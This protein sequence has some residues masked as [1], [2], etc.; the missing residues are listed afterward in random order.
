MANEFNLPNDPLL[1]GKIIDS[2]NEIIKKKV[3]HGFLGLFWGSSSSIPNNI[4]A[5]TIV[6]LV[7]FGVIYSVS[8]SNTKTEEIGLTIKDCWAI[9]SPIIMLAFGYLF[10]ENT[11][12]NTP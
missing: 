3:E 12:K 8:I 1:A 10:G 6:V 7:F 4:A 5:L 9:I 11:K 2:N